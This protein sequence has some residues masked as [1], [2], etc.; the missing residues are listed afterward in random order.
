M[1]FSLMPETQAAMLRVRMEVPSHTWTG[2]RSARSDTGEQGS[3]KPPTPTAHWRGIYSDRK[4]T[5]V[6]QQ[7]GQTDGQRQIDG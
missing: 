4:T 2:L 3:R 1:S 7:H 6:D 5:Q